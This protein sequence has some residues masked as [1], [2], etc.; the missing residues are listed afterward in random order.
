MPAMA[1][2]WASMQVEKIR[3]SVLPRAPAM[4]LPRSGAYTCTLPSAM[5]SAP[6]L[7]TAVTTTSPPRA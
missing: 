4:A 2:S 3:A 1:T 7:T 6:K 5:T